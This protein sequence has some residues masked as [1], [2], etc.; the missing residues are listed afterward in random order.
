MTASPAPLP[1]DQPVYRFRHM[2]EH[3]LEM[4][5]LWLSRPHVQ[6]WWGRPGDQFEL[7]SEDLAEPGMDQYVVSLG[8]R[9][10]AYLQC[11]LGSAYPENGL[12]EHP[13][14]TR[15]IDQFIG[16][17]DLVGRGHG[18]AFVRAFVVGLLTAGAPRVITD[19]DPAN[20]RAIRA[21]TKA[22]FRPDG[23]VDTPDGRALLMIRDNSPAG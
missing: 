18:S 22:G 20:A 13:P 10:F 17:P 12:G 16:E 9:P 14:G 3:D 11:Y 21:Y 4:V 6:E 2:T 5:R 1:Q 19:P 23:L 7:V 15:G 8:D